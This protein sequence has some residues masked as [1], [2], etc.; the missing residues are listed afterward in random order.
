MIVNTLIRESGGSVLKAQ[1]H[2]NQN[3]HYVEYYIN[4]NLVRVQNYETNSVFVIE[5]DIS[6]WLNS[7]STING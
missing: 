3:T 5:S 1:I 4:D 6:N 7:V 2:K